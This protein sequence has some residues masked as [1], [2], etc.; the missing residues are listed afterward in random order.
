MK[1][2]IYDAFSAIPRI[3]VVP[4]PVPVSHG[5]LIKV[6]ATGV[7]LSDWHGWKGHDPDIRLPHVPGHE[8]AGVIAAVG[9]DVNRWHI[10]ERVTVPF[11]SGCG[12]CPECLSGNHHICDRFDAMLAMVQAGKLTPGKL[13]GRTISLEQSIEALVNMEKFSNVGVTVI[14]EF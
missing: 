2:V 1:A 8:L 14:T 9:K 13:I 11:V 12:V 4:D 10:D 3:Q 6:M 5:V 7:C